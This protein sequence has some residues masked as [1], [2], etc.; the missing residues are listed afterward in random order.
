V[1]RHVAGD[2]SA[3]GL[4]E[5]IPV[6]AMCPRRSERNV[7]TS[8]ILYCL[9]ETNWIRIL[10]EIYPDI[11]RGQ[12]QTGL[13]KCLW[14]YRKIPGTTHHPRCPV[15]FELAGRCLLT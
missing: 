13:T 10:A 1:I 3:T 14:L 15:S 5:S 2:F 9:V 7:V 6:I 11:R 4:V 12:S 8:G